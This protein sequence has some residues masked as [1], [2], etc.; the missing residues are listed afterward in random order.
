MIFVV[1][2]EAFLQE[3]KTLNGMNFASTA[4]FQASVNSWEI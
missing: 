4:Q 2:K 1:A 3:F